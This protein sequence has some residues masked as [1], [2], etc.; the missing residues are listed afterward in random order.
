[1]HRDRSWVAKHRSEAD[2]PKLPD[3][4]RTFPTRSCL[5]IRRLVAQTGALVAGDTLSAIAVKNNGKSGLFRIA[6]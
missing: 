1:M 3:Y 6:R 4:L 5:H 2:A